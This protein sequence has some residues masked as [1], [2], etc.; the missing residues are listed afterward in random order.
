[1][2]TFELLDDRPC[3]TDLLTALTCLLKWRFNPSDV[4]SSES[5]I[6]PRALSR[7]DSEY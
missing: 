5:L 3:T 6:S 2:L 1:M 7:T 4:P